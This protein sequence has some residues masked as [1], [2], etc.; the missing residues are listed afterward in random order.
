[1]VRD[2]AF[3]TIKIISILIAILIVFYKPHYV[4]YV[5][6][7]NI[8]VTIPF[9][10]LTLA[11][12]AMIL[13]YILIVYVKAIWHFYVW[14]ILYFI[15][16]IYFCIY[17]MNF[18]IYSTIGS[19]VFPFIIVLLYKTSNINL[20][21]CVWTV[22]RAACLTTLYFSYPSKYLHCN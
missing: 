9:S 22:V 3:H 12:V 10:S 15:W 16:N 2:I 5:I 13:I 8:L 20:L 19:N 21:I 18:N 7:L 17:S 6:A 1:M 11:L 14:V 4:V